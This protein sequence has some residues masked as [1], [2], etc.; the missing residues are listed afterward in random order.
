MLR[1]AGGQA[2]RLLEA[3]LKDCW[4]PAGQL[5]EVL[6]VTGNKLVSDLIY[7]VEEI[8]VNRTVWSTGRFAHKLRRNVLN[9]QKIPFITD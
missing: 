1:V 4:R 7:A 3:Q 8:P 6:G 2:Q 9:S 5:L